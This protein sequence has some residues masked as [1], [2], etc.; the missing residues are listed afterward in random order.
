MRQDA[1]HRI[2]IVDHDMEAQEQMARALLDAGYTE[3]MRADSVEL[4]R[5]LAQESG[6]FAL[7]ILSVQMPD[8]H[9]QALLQELAP[10]APETAVIMVTAQAGLMTAIDCLRK[11]AYDYVLKPLGADGIQMSVAMALKRRQRELEELASFFEV[12]EE[13]EQRVSMLE[14]T[15]S[16]LLWAVCGLAEFRTPHG[17]VHPERVARYSQIMTEELARR[18]PY[19]PFITKQFLQNISEAALLHDIGKLALPDSV[20]FKSGELTA[21]EE[22]VVESHTT[23]GRDICTAVRRELSSPADSFVDM[24]I[25]V[26]GSHHERWDGEGYP[27]KLAGRDIPLSARIVAL[28]DY[29]D[30]WRT[31]M[32]YR[33]EILPA[34]KVAE[35]ITRESGR[36]FDPIIVDAF[37]RCRSPIAQ[38]EEELTRE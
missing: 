6:P 25:E 14:E 3:I 34:E 26:T 7:V 19:A 37:E 21:E 9:G 15:R 32:T 20:I 30:I 36:K 16:A 11:G 1:M 5:R 27:D 12:E 28:A 29:Y 13:V 23:L 31:P 8:E 17:H 22:A 18:S 4:A 10:L 35:V 2:L 24:A 33:P 38:A